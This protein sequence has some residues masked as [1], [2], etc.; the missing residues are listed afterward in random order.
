MPD[1]PSPPRPEQP[2]GQ[3]LDDSPGSDSA[4]PRA[5]TDAGRA[6][7]EALRAIA[8]TARSFLYYDAG[9][10]AIRDALQEVARVVRLDRESP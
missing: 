7:V 9:N 2:A 3:L 1:P 10:D 8:R 4:A 6:A 5:S